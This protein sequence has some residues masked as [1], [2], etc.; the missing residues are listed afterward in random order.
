MS[1]PRGQEIPLPLIAGRTSSLLWAPD[2]LRKEGTFDPGGV[3]HRNMYQT[4]QFSST[5]RVKLPTL[6]RTDLNENCSLH[7]DKPSRAQFAPF[8]SKSIRSAKSGTCDCRGFNFST[9]GPFYFEESEQ[10]GTH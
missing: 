2:Y 10:E 3:T 5:P 6:L 9:S 1:D 7:R 8:E 4:E